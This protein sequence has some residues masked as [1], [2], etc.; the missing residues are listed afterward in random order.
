MKSGIFFI[1]KILAAALTV[2]P[3]FPPS[4][5][6]MEKPVAVADRTSDIAF[7]AMLAANALFLLSFIAVAMYA[8][9]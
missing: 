1:A 7:K 6:C 9:L 2:W 8:S 5:A 3:L 4:V